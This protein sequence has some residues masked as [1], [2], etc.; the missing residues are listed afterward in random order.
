MKIQ[1]SAAVVTGGA[2]GLGLAVVQN[3]L[4]AGAKVGI[5]DLPKEENEK[6]VREL[7]E[8]AFFLPADVSQEDK[9]Q[10]ALDAMDKTHPLRIAVNCAGIAFAIKTLQKDKASD[11]ASFKMTL[12]VNLVGTFNVCRLAAE[13][14][15][16]NEANADGERG[17]LINTSS[18]AAYDGQMG[19]VA[20]AASK[21]GIVAMTL[22][23]ARDLA[24]YGIRVLTIAPG[25]FDTPLLAL[26]PESARQSLAEQVPFPH[27]LGLPSEF[28]ALAQHMIENPMLNGEVVRLDGALRMGLK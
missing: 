28:A 8:N 17:V 6:K 2:S 7:G 11:L 27:R 5:I 9:V 21:G 15:A 14:M 10:S 20:Y 4:K 23:M 22:P 26:L 1:N 12:E 18:I 13:R 19:Q 25:I 24:K 16:K 3:L